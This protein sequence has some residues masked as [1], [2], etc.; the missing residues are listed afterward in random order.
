M[1]SGIPTERIVLAGFSQGGAIA[2]FAGLRERRPLAGIIAL[3]SYLLF[4]DRLEAEA[5]AANRELPIF[6]AHGRQDPV[7]L[8]E[9]GRSSR[10]RLLAAG[11]PV[12]WREYDIAHQVNLPELQEVAAFLESRL[13]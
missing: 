4:P 5:A 7:V 8:P 1:E 6:Q 11:Y 10:D 9:L 13:S 12:E 2:L 3:S